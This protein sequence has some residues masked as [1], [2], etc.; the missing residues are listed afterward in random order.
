MCIKENRTVEVT[1]EHHPIHGVIA[2]KAENASELIFENA[3]VLSRILFEPNL[4][5]QA[6]Q[7][8]EPYQ[9]EKLMNVL[10]AETEFTIE[11]FKEGIKGESQQTLSITYDQEYIGIHFIIPY[12]CYQK[13]ATLITDFIEQT[14]KETGL[15][16][17]LRSNEE[18]LFSNIWQPELRQDGCEGLTMVRNEQGQVIVDLNQFPGQN[19]TYQALQFTSC[20]QMWFCQPYYQWLPKQVLKDFREG[21][22]NEAKDFGVTHITLYKDPTKWQQKENIIRQWAF[23]NQCGIDEVTQHLVLREPFVEVAAVTEKQAIYSV[24]YLDDYWRPTSKLTATRGLFRIYDDRGEEILFEQRKGTVAHPED[25]FTKKTFFT[26]EWLTKIE[27]FTEMLIDGGLQICQFYLHRYLHLKMDLDKKKSKRKLVILVPKG[28]LE[29]LN[30]EVLLAPYV[31][32]KMKKIKQGCSF[33]IKKKKTVLHVV[34]FEGKKKE[35]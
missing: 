8:A 17:Y 9:Q 14:L 22:S 15:F 1:K 33:V 2:L 13:H 19:L 11:V 23:R 24:Q 4:M 21:V 34:I 10:K 18:R 12:H 3:I 7:V 29:A 32:Q 35:A 16:A 6:E 5:R 25:Y 20:W 31:V 27:I 30:V 28:G 26:Q